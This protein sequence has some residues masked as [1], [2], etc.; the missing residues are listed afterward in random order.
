MY[1]QAQNG[2]QQWIL[3]LL[4]LVFQLTRIIDI[5]LSSL[6]KIQHHTWTV[7]PQRLTGAPSYFSQVLYQDLAIFQFLRNLH[8]FTM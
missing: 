5:Y 4:S 3:A 8:S 2:S 7:M 1:L 6:R